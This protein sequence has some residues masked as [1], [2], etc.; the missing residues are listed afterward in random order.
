A[1]VSFHFYLFFGQEVRPSKEARHILYHRVLRT[2]IVVKRFNPQTEEQRTKKVFIIAFYISAIAMLSICFYALHVSAGEYL[3]SN[4]LVIGEVLVNTEFPIQG[5]PK[6]VTYLMIT[7]IVSWFCVTKLAGDKV[8]VIPE[9]VKSLFQL[10]VLAIAVIALYEFVYNFIL[11]NSFL[12]DEVISGDF[13]SDG[14]SVPYPN[15]ETPW[16]LVFATKMT[17][18]AFLISAHAFYIISKSKRLGQSPTG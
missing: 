16:N 17:M 14:I 5:S 4:R 2:N 8:M 3:R 6:L 15:P 9:S 12:A 13:G 10:L 11:W 1:V 7:S 18:A